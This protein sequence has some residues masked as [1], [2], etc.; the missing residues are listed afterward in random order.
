MSPRK[1][2]PVATTIPEVPQRG[3]AVNVYYCEVT[4]VARPFVVGGQQN[5][6]CHDTCEWWPFTANAVG[7]FTLRVKHG[8]RA[9]AT[10]SA[11]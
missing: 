9:L 1:M 10:A 2:S 6:W 7:L 4:S 8:D 11:Q 5:V 3:V